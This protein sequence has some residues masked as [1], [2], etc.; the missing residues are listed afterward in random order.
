MD[1]QHL[2]VV[3]EVMG[4]PVAQSHKPLR[5]TTHVLA[6]ILVLA[7]FARVR[8]H[9]LIIP[10]LIWGEFEIGSNSSFLARCLMIPKLLQ[11]G[12][13]VGLSVVFL[14]NLSCKFRT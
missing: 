10:K 9:R 11:E 7:V 2:A 3:A 6:P 1:I 14:E 5:V 12:L 13:L 8:L 4:R